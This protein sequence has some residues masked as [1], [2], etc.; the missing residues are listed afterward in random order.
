ML[1]PLNLLLGY[2]FGFLLGTYQEE[3]IWA[4]VHYGPGGGIF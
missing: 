2:A 1:S 3:I 4:I